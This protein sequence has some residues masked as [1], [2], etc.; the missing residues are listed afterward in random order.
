VDDATPN[1]P[2]DHGSPEAVEPEVASG[3]PPA[4]SPTP[5]TMP[6]PP[7]PTAA[8]PTWS[9]STGWGSPPP[10]VDP[11]SPPVEPPAASDDGAG[12]DP[13]GAGGEPTRPVPAAP[14]RFGSGAE[15]PGA[16]LGPPPNPPGPVYAV[17]PVP[18]SASGNE[19]RRGRGRVLVAG[20]V[21]GALIG[22]GV[23]GGI[24]YATRGTNTVVKEAGTTK[25]IVTPA[26]IDHPVTTQSIIAKV[27]P[28]VVAIRSAANAQALQTSATLP[29]GGAAGT[30][31][32]IRS[33][34]TILTNYHV[35]SGAGAIDATFPD[36]S[37]HTATVLGTS[38][39][40]DIAVLKI[41]GSNFP[42]VKLGVSSDAQVGEDVVAIGNALALEGGLTVTTGILSS[43]NRTVQEPSANGG[44]GAELTGLL[45][46][47]AAINP[48]NSGGPLVNT[49]GEVIGINTAV[50]SDQQT[51]GAA[52]GIG[53]AI[54]ID[55][56]KPLLAQLE[57]GQSEQRAYL[58]VATIDNSPVVAR[59]AGLTVS[60]G[61][62]IKRVTA[63]TPADAAGLQVGDVIIKIDGK[64]VADSSGVGV[65]IHAHKPGDRVK[66]TF[67]RGSDT[68]TVTVILG[69][70]PASLGS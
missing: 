60:T 28:A 52:Q 44:T 43:T 10:P 1:Q 53:F 4:S 14:T 65:I 45:Q 18:P 57:A 30:G 49:A 36:G 17:T 68:H 6:E 55:T 37:R 29:D 22:G 39:D 64:T 62:F 11:P 56:I 63:N 15:G 13:F 3:P 16:P 25:T 26:N 66:I 35:V 20:I 7:R 38:P 67:V 41:S 31:F 61:A 23:G 32:V 42:T 19:K 48:G 50:A 33:N 24:S 70:A 5:P 8:D 59:E 54:S 40:N 34:G 58:G 46:T 21:I 51:G 9:A 2:N 47:D 27:E 12:Y 69:K